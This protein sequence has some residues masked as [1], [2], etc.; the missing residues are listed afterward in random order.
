[1]TKAEMT[2][3][4]SGRLSPKLYRHSIATQQL[5]AELAEMYGADREK[6]NIAGLLHDCAKAL[7]NAELLSHAELYRL[8]VDEIQLM[9]PGLLH[10]PVAAK[11]VQAELGITD[12]EILHAISV[13]NT[14]CPGMSGL[15]R[16]LYL[17]DCSEPDREYPGV[18]TIRELIIGGDLNGALLVAMDRKIS[19]VIQKRQMLH[20]LSVDARNDL[21][22]EIMDR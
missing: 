3:W 13:H 16:A 20:P 6:A 21:L 8:P 22:K 2:D 15:D 5:T 12:E 19:Y 18:E 4:I 1:M 14:G 11:L 17:A 7:S 9:Q 10:A